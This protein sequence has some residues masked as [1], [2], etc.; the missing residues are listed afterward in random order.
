MMNQGTL[1][2]GF[3]VLTIIVEYLLAT[4]AVYKLL[5]HLA[6][7]QDNQSLQK[8]DDDVAAERERL[9]QPTTDMVWCGVVRFASYCDVLSPSLM[10]Y[11]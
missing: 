5:G 9:Q 3:F 4:P 1:S 10:R 11:Q 2:F 7:T 6:D 8:E